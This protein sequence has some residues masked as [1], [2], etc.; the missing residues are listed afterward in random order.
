MP[1]LLSRFKEAEVRCKATLDR[2]AATKKAASESNAANLT[3]KGLLTSVLGKR[4][5]IELYE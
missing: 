1:V 4:D 5:R 2:V 3:G